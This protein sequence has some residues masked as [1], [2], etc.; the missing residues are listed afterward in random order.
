MGENP[1]RSWGLR[2]QILF[3]APLR[4]VLTAA[5]VRQ[6]AGRGPIARAGYG[7]PGLGNLGAVFFRF[8]F[9]FVGS[10]LVQ[11]VFFLF[12]FQYFRI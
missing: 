8:F 4:G 10:F 11:S 2:G 9:Y 3:I 12:Y 1:R 5:R 6:L 7:S